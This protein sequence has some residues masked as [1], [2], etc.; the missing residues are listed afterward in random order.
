MIVGLYAFE[1]ITT[2]DPALDFACLV[3]TQLRAF[4]RR[5][6][7]ELDGVDDLRPEDYIGH[8]HEDLAG[9]AE[10]FIAEADQ[11]GGD[12]LIGYRAEGHLEGRN[13]PEQGHLPVDGFLFHE[14]ED[15]RARSAE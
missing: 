2:L 1:A 14:R 5:D 13:A 11:R 10:A 8:N 15:G 4:G 3:L 12:V 6:R 9:P 7:A